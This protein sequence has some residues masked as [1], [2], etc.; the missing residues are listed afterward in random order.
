MFVPSG[1]N[2]TQLE[3]FSGQL[4]LQSALF[5]IA[6][7][8]IP[9]MLL[10]KPILLLLDH[11]Y[12]QQGY[13]SFFGMLMGK[14]DYLLVNH[15]EG[16]GSLVLEETSQPVSHPVEQAHGGGGH[17][18]EEFE[19]SELMVHQ[20]LETIEFVLGCVSHTASY[21]RLWALSL[22]HSE[23]A[24]V[25]W[26]KGFFTMWEIALGTHSLFVVGLITFVCFSLWFGASLLVIVGM[27]SLSA[28]LHAL[29]LH[30][31]EFQSKFYRG[32]GY[33]FTP[34]SYKAGDEQ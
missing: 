13:S 30:W 19:F 18:H 16:G 11:K 21:L 7:I 31:V 1:G 4:H 12:Q 27:E 14:K 15:S 32:D 23:L 10:P 6:I 34:F 22:A 17:G 20:G 33:P 26:E 5:Y 28:F 29:R 9:F 25:F 2:Y 8:C 3:L 24:T